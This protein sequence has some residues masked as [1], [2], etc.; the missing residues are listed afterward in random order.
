MGEA[1]AGDDGEGKAGTGLIHVYFFGDLEQGC[2]SFVGLSK[3]ELDL[4]GSP[5]TI[6]QL[7]DYAAFTLLESR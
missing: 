4:E 2:G 7:E 5:G 1:E 6:G 3:A